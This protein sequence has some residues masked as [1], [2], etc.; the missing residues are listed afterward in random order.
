MDVDPPLLD[1]DMQSGD[2]P[3]GAPDVDFADAAATTG[4]DT[5]MEG[6]AEMTVDTTLD[7][8]VEMGDEDYAGT[9][10]GG[11]ISYDS[12]TAS[13]VSLA[14]PE[15][16]RS[17][18][19]V[20]DRDEG[21]QTQALGHSST[22]DRL[23]A[24]DDQGGEEA[25]ARGHEEGSRANGT[26][27]DDE[28]PEAGP[29]GSQQGEDDGAGEDDAGDDGA[30]ENGAEDDNKTQSQRDGRALASQRQDD[31]QDGSNGREQE[32]TVEDKSRHTQRL[33]QKQK[34][35]R[36][37]G[38]E[39]KQTNEVNIREDPEDGGV[40]V[41][42]EQH[43]QGPSKNSPSDGPVSQVNVVNVLR[44][45]DD[46]AS[47]SASGASLRRP[48]PNKRPLR[49]VTFGPTLSRYFDHFRGRPSISP[50]E[51][52]PTGTGHE[53]GR[54][55]APPVR[56]TCDGVLYDLFCPPEELDQ[57]SAAD[58]EDGLSRERE[59]PATKTLFDKHDEHQLYFNHLETLCARLH[60]AFP[61]FEKDKDEMVLV[62]NELGISVP[63]VRLAV[64]YPSLHSDCGV[65]RTTF[66]PGSCLSTTWTGYTSELTWPAGCTS[67]SN[68]SRG[69]FTDSTLSPNTSSVS[70]KTVRHDCSRPP[71]RAD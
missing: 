1:A 56:L 60:E 27:H 10:E 45:G 28:E 46:C 19:R 21:H 3:A 50:T 25:E 34:Q 9:A 71:R 49:D 62:F 2:D 52:A 68:G 8:E 29:S 67:R 14:D 24:E 30:G 70:S 55:R 41:E 69:S 39:A 17:P 12:E 36:G 13:I 65:D 7:A 22:A 20:M 6:D 57:D 32:Q 42:T 5:L 51:D 31:A 59:D 66:T 63:E 33:T 4:E 23:A 54:L 15:P 37:N 58:D 18:P 43:N 38:E 53:D 61:Q 47:N 64:L 35:D 26:S 44:Q 11:T 48:G 40:E 16:F